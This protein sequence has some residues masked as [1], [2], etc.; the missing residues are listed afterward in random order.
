[1]PRE[2]KIRIKYGLNLT[3]IR[4]LITVIDSTIFYAE[5]RGLMWESDSIFD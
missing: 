3:H 2:I 1:M 5:Y 4:N